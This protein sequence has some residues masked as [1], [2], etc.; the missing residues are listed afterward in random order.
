M[1]SPFDAAVAS[2]GLIHDRVMGETFE[3]HPMTRTDGDVNK[4][5]AVVVDPARA[6]VLN[7]LAVWGDPSARAHS[8]AVRT[9]GVEAEQA[10]HA[11][12]RPFISLDVSRLPYEAARDDRIKRLATGKLYKLAEILPSQPGYARFDL[13]LIG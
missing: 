11:T 6:V 12:S 5:A 10:G 2:A 9:V 7:L 1:V 8:G 13:N 3:F 4:R